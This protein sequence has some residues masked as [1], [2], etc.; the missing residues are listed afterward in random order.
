MEIV[1]RFQ[2]RNLNGLVTRANF[3]G[4]TVDYWAPEKATNHLI[5]AHDGQNIFDPKTATRGRTWDLAQTAS[6]VFA[7]RGLTPPA[8]IAIFHATTKENLWGRAQDLAPQQPFQNGLVVAQA[9]YRDIALEDLRSDEYLEQIALTIIPAVTKALKISPTPEKISLLGSSMGGLAT[10]YGVARYPELFRTG[11]AFSP[12][13]VVGEY[14]LV[15][16]LL[17]Q[18]PSPERHKIWMSRGTKSLDA[19]YQPFQDYADQQLKSLGWGD[20]S[21]FTSRIFKGDRHSER[22]WRRQVEPALKFWLES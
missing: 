18:L 22:S 3:H 9:K 16:A 11:F 10:L 12:H 6:R 4:R 5:V 1:Q 17:A 2:I 20:S 19:Q 15:D 21:Q 7:Q 14:A 8:I 13:W